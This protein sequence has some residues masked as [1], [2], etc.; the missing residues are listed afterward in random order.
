[1]F[2]S[3]NAFDASVAHLDDLVAHRSQSEI[4]C[5]DDDAD[6]SFPAGVLQQLEDLLAGLI[7][8]SSGRLIAKQQLWILGQGTGD[9][10]SLL[11]T[12]GELSRKVTRTIRQTN[13][14][15]R[16]IDIQWMLAD[17]C[18]QFDVFLDRQILDQIIK[19][20][21]K[22]NIV[23]PIGRQ[24]F[25]CVITDTIAIYDDRAAG[26]TVHTAQNI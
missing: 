2:V 26:R 4:M 5:D 20:K 10:H 24:L 13:S 9:R 8:Q 25:R 12:A 22:T 19:L 17:L 21:D 14:S 7:V 6:A 16:L 3:F 11:F 15:D 1:M 18:G 23:A